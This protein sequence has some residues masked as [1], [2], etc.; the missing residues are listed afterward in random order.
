MKP[1]VVGD[2][3]GLGLS[4]SLQDLT[5][6]LGIRPLAADSVQSWLVG[7]LAVLVSSVGSEVSAACTFYI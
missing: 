7:L 3:R 4:L 5:P 6:G 2:I 1:A